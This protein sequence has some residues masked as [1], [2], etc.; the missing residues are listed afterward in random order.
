MYT[1]ESPKLGSHQPPLRGLSLGDLLDALAVVAEEAAQEALTSNLG[2]PAKPLL[3]R[4][5]NLRLDKI[6]RYL[7]SKA[8]DAKRRIPDGPAL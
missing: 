2:P 7:S 3:D 4:R 6:R 5:F 1:Q 8:F